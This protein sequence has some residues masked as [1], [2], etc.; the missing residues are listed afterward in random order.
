MF[1]RGCS[2]PLRK[3][4]VSVDGSGI[5]KDVLWV[6]KEVPGTLGKVLVAVKQVQW[7]PEEISAPG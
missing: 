3:L 4:G 1:L 7:V 6:I 5:N 2:G